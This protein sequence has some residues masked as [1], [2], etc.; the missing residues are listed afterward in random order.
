M[1]KLTQS[2]TYTWPVAVHVPV[3]GGQYD[4]QTFDGEF[5]R[6]PDSRLKEIG[7]KVDAGEMPDSDFVRE[8]MVGWCGIT[9]DGV[10]VPFSNENLERLLEVP[11]VAG[12][13]ALAVID[14]LSGLKRKN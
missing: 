13:V 5:K 8:V 6:L 7:R 11:G 4:K 1:F 9:A 14:S 2:A 3:N 12:A 10:E